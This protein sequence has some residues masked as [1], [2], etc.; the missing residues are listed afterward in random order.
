M[1]SSVRMPVVSVITPTFNH[2]RYLGLCVES[3]LAQ[4]FTDWEMI[5]LDTG[6]T[7]GTED[8]AQSF[9]DSRIIYVRQERRGLERLAETYNSGLSLAKAP[10]VAI[11]EGDDVWPQDKLA[12]QV[13][14]LQ[15]SSGVLCYGVAGL[16]DE[17][18]RVFGRNGRLPR[19]QAVLNNR[20]V[21]MILR[22][23]LF[24]DF[25]AWPT[26]VIRRKALEQIGGFVQAPGG[27]YVDYPTCL[28][29]SLVSEFVFLP[30]VLGFW[31]RHFGQHTWGNA[32]E[33][34]RNGRICARAFFDLAIKEGRVPNSFLY[35]SDKLQR[36]EQ[37]GWDYSLLL[38]GRAMLLKGDWPGARSAFRR[39]LVDGKSALR[40]VG[41]AGLGASIV[42]RDLEWLARIAGVQPWR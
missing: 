24:N 19:C 9:K 37:V 6:S 39:L 25:I 22:N 4:T 15:S 2:D 8:V 38:D 28:H 32:G 29:L 5:I 40:F 13:S 11:L 16:I 20:P 1:V 36:F 21:G 12:K 18:G 31:R 7:D 35:L 14:V 26:V 3:V 17:G 34:M 33:L 23:L 42:R 30:E 27:T 41:I 10:F